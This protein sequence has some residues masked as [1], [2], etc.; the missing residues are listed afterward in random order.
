VPTR[1]AAIAA[2]VAGSVA[3]AGSAGGEPARVSGPC[4]THEYSYAGIA[5]QHPAYG[6]HTKLAALVAPSVEQG[7]VAAWI[8]MGGPGEGPAGTDEWIQVGLSAFP[9]SANSIYYEVARPHA[10]ASYVQVTSGVPA[11]EQHRFAV[12]EMARRRSWWRVWVDGR[13]ASPPIYLPGSHGMW[14]PV[15]TAESWNGGARACN[16]YA[17]DFHQV[18]VATRAGGSWRRLGSGFVHHDIG[19]QV[20]EGSSFSSFLASAIFPYARTRTLVEGRK[21]VE[22]PQP[23]P[24]DEPAGPPAAQ[25]DDVGPNVP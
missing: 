12:L 16:G 23:D 13:P 8:G 7:H 11:G 22:L 3:L 19:Y 17:F 20:H 21:V 15:A 2:I 5:G 18:S 1:V 14:A 6:A 10:A 25:P 4:S 24:G 9:D